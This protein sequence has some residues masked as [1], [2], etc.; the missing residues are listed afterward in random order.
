[1][2]RYVDHADRRREIVRATVRVLAHKGLSALTVRSVAD[3]LG[4][5]VA[6]V[7]HYYRTRDEMINDLA[8]QMAARWR[9]AVTELDAGGRSPE[10][11][12]HALLVWALPKSED[13]MLMEKA[14][15]QLLAARDEFPDVRSV[16]GSWDTSMRSLFR[17]HIRPLV[18][19]EDVEP[20]VDMLRAVISGITF[21]AYQH[22]WSVER[23]H[24]VLARTL[25][26]L[27]LLAT[28]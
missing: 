1:M 11:R 20:T 19:E 5:S 10:E 17:E 24:E 22:G 13:Q 25:R 9:T 21:E 28:D 27:G 18:P 14:R 4:G 3:E 15:L 7:T 6:L 8:V 16:F 23:Q 2:P 12:L 26:K